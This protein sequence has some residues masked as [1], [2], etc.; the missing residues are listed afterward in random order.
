MSP[1][2][3]ILSYVW[4]EGGERRLVYEQEPPPVLSGPVTIL[5][6]SVCLFLTNLRVCLDAE[7]K[8]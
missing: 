8:M 5:K 7:G 1:I 2:A 3:I 6:N 4:V